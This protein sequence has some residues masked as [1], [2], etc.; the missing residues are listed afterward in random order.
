[1]KNLKMSLKL[2][3]AFGA[4]IVFLAVIVTFSSTAFMTVE[5]LLTDFYEEPYADVQLADELMLDITFAA[6]NMLHASSTTDTATTADCL[7]ASDKYIADMETALSTLQA[8]Y[9]GDMADVDAISVNITSLKATLASFRAA[10]ESHDVTGAVT[11]FE[12]EMLPE[13]D[14]VQA[15][16]NNIR[17]YEKTMADR[18]Y[19]EANRRADMTI[20]IITAI[21]VV[22]V[23]VSIILAVCI[24][25]LIVKAVKNVDKAAVQM[26]EGNFDVNIT[27]TSKDELGS[28][29]ESMR[30][31]AGRTNAVISDIDY[32]LERIAEGD[33]NTDTENEQL[34]IGAFENILVSFRSFVDKL[35]DTMNQIN[36]AADQVSTGSEQVAAGATALS[37]GATEQAS[38]VEEL[39]A[40]IS[41][42]ADMISQNAKDAAS[43]NDMTNA[44]GA[45][46]AEASAK[47][48]DL[49]KAMQEISAFSDETKKI[50]KTIEDIA[51][52]TNILALNASIEAARAGEAGKGFAVVADE[53]GN[54]AAK[55][56]EA[57][58]STTALIESTVDAIDKGGELVDEVA[59]KMG[60]VADAAGQVAQ[61]NVTISDAAKEAEESIRQVTVGADQISAVVQTNSATAEQSAA[62]SEEL[63]GQANM[64]KELIGYFSLKEE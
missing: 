6:E 24:S 34:Y 23:I 1:M 45:E 21:G 4:I 44:A 7:A 36:V 42:I 15:A 9:T 62:A 50:I 59:V 18:I 49:V 48:A 11:I 43:A 56:A 12:N 46:M 33:L 63:S 51:F 54:L 32:Q 30:R 38:S 31:M 3:V 53:V 2:L 37:Q 5:G 10:A 27:Y 17:E 28:L 14:A 20:I 13:I 64:L 52:Q 60:V 22:A 29:A 35:N 55:S 19:G 47:M 8:H 25:R 26:A 40:T 41:V 57:A 58:Q 16:V 39:S 61:I